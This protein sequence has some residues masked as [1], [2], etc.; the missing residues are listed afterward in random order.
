M[1][2]IILLGAGAGIILASLY[3]YLE[4]VPSDEETRMAMIDEFREH[5]IYKKFKAMYPNSIE[6]YDLHPSPMLEVKQSDS[7]DNTLDLTFSKGDDVRPYYYSVFCNTDRWLNPQGVPFEAAFDFLD[8][9]D[10]LQD[11]P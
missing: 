11:Y 9:N 2:K 8:D 3:V 7:H 1:N 5:E 6:S 10:C 4:L